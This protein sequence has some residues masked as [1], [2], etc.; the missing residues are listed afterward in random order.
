MK[1][2]DNPVTRRGLLAALSSVYD[3]LGLRAPFLLKCHQI[4]NLR[5]NNL[6]WDDPIDDSSYTNS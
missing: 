3:P 1:M 2:S 6:T 5:R 4:I